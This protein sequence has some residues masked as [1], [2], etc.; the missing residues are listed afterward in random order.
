MR[1]LICV[2]SAVLIASPSRRDALR[3][4]RAA[5][6]VWD[7]GSLIRGLSFRPTHA[8]TRDGPKAPRSKGLEAISSHAAYVA[9]SMT[10]V[11]T[12]W[13]RSAT[14]K[15]D[16]ELAPLKQ[17]VFDDHRRNEHCSCRHWATRR[18]NPIAAPE[19][20]QP[21]H[22]RRTP[23]EAT[24]ELSLVRIRT[25][26][27]FLERICHLSISSSRSCERLDGN[28]H[29]GHPSHHS[30]PTH[31]PSNNNSRSRPFHD[32]NNNHSTA[33]SHRWRARIRLAAEE[34]VVEKTGA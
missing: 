6:G 13:L 18:S 8:E 34:G 29:V 21:T 27:R 16:F 2:A 12:C 24:Q 22:G 10:E 7:T 33:S 1:C 14:R 20:R 15:G 28:N 3:K 30:S 5:P 19:G 9:R 25:G 32:H 11:S 17:E 26:S 31:F 23:L 4:H